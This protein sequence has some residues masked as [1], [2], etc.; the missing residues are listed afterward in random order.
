MFIDKFIDFNDSM[1]LL[2]FIIMDG[3]TVFITLLCKVRLGEK[4]FLSTSSE[5]K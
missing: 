2:L 1:N 4:S 3:Y 5:T